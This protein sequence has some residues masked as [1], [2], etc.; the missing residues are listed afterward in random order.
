MV[1]RVQLPEFRTAGSNP[2]RS[3]CPGSYCGGT[4]R[5]APLGVSGCR[6]MVRIHLGAFA[7]PLRGGVMGVSNDMA[8]RIFCFCVLGC[9]GFFLGCK[10]QP[11]VYEIIEVSNGSEMRDMHRPIR[12]GEGRQMPEVYRSHRAW[13]RS[14]CDSK[15][16]RNTNPK[17]AA[18]VF[19]SN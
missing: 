4:R 9:F 2:A 15:D 17:S 7:N 10:S 18:T 12:R 8:N 6:A 19:G 16:A 5:H 11:T 3:F 13:A 14:N 1:H